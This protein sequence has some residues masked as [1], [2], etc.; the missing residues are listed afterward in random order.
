LL[1]A[2][3]YQGAFSVEWEYAWHPELDAP[4]IALPSALRTVRESL[5]T[6]QTESA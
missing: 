4:E 1:L 6:A 3:G 5:A 2:H